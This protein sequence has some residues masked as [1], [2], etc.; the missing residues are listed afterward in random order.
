MPERLYTAEEVGAHQASEAELVA[1]PLR[2]LGE[3]LIYR[4]HHVQ[5]PGP[6]GWLRC[7]EAICVRARRILK[8]HYFDGDRP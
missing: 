6:E 7:Q 5:H 3:D 1:E 4:L 8:P 2:Q